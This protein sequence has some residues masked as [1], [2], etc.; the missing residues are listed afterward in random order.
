LNSDSLDRAVAAFK[1]GLANCSNPAVFYSNIGYCYLTRTAPDSAVKYFKQAI[2]LD[3]GN[4]DNYY[5]L[6]YGLTKERDLNESIKSLRL[7]IKYDP[8]KIEAYYLLGSRLASK[9]P[10]TKEETGEAIRALDLF[11][12]NDQGSM[13]QND[14]AKKKLG[15]LRGDQ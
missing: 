4:A 5:N 12:K 1:Q 2:A 9:K 6:A 15:L 11:L 13:I 14:I 7:A 8:Q 10:R 3:P